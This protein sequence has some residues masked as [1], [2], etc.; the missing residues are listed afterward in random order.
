VIAENSPDLIKSAEESAQILAPPAK[1]NTAAAKAPPQGVLDEAMRQATAWDRTN[2][3]WRS[4]PSFLDEA[5]R[6]ATAWDSTNRARRSSEWFDGDKTTGGVFA[7]AARHGAAQLQAHGMAKESTLSGAINAL[8]KLLQSGINPSRGGGQ[9]YTAQ[10]ALEKGQTGVQGATASGVAYR[11]GPFILVQNKESS[12]RGMG[13]RDMS[14]VAAILINEA[15]ADQ[16]E[17]LRALF[18]SVRP[19]MIVAPYS[20]V[21]SVTDSLMANAD[22]LN[23]D[24]SQGFT[25]L[26]LS[27]MVPLTEEERSNVSSERGAVDLRS[28]ANI[29]KEADSFIKGFANTPKGG[30]RIITPVPYTQLTLPTK[31]KA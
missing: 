18:Q 19:D 21:V 31:R 4:F 10:L 22:A 25:D 8:L 1:T 3:H 16:V 15:H 13:I 6:Q 23:A 20:D 11:D 26:N 14:E 27:R 12:A 28:P 2:S 9:L 30:V 7:E 24:E 17:A 5:M 29:Q